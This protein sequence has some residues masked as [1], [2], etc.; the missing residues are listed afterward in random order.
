MNNLYVVDKD[1]YPKYDT[2]ILQGLCSD[3]EY[4]G[5]FELKDGQRCIVCAYDSET[6]NNKE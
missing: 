3:W 2:V 4:Y 6:N 5:E 1:Y